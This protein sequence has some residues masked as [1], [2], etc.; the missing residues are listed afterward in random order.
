MGAGQGAQG[1]GLLA[2]S[3]WVT[4]LEPEFTFPCDLVF[5]LSPQD[6]PFLLA[7]LLAVGPAGRPYRQVSLQEAVLSFLFSLFILMKNSQCFYCQI[8]PCVPCYTMF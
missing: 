1:W 3:P 7:W 6:L 4:N 5:H 8:E 2:Q